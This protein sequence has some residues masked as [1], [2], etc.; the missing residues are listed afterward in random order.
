MAFRDEGSSFRDAGDPFRDAGRSFR[1][2]E[3]RSSSRN[4]VPQRGRPLPRDGCPV[5]VRFVAGTCPKCRDIVLGMGRS[6]ATHGAPPSFVRVER[7]TGLR[8]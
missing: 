1:D 6:E 3:C 5:P 2:A 7:K 8:E 4:A